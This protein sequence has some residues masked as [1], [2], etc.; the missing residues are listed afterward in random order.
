MTFRIIAI[1]VVF[2]FLCTFSVK[3]C[4]F[5]YI[6]P[7]E[8]GVWMTNGGMNGAADYQVWYGHFPIDMNPLTKSFTI[9][10]QPWTIDLPQRT[11]YSQQNGEWVV[12]PQCT[13]RVDKNQ[14]PSVCHANNNLLNGDDE[15]FLEAVGNHLLTLK[16]NDVINEIIGSNR[17]TFLLTNKVLVGRMFE[18]SVRARFARFG[19]LVDAFTSG[20]TPPESIIA[21]N[22]AKN[23][24][25]QSVYTAKADGIKAEAD[26]KVNIIKAESA[27]KVALIEAQAEATSTRLKEQSLTP[28]MIQSQWIAK[29]DGALPYY[30]A[31]GNSSTIMQMP[32]PK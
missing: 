1:A 23:L 8:V 11:V 20:I 30:Q 26:A 25:E 15:K 2:L 7:N 16:I 17:D 31:G 3:M 32:V 27:A 22:R 6:Q 10:A 12:D 19:Y 24:A 4:M 28:L 13:F 14:A 18:D 21:T 5:K 9:P 29:W